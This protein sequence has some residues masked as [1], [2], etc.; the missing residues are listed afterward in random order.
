MTEW[1][2]LLITL[3][4]IDLLIISNGYEKIYTDPSGYLEYAMSKVIRLKSKFW[5]FFV[6]SIYEGMLIFIK[7][8]SKPIW[9]WIQFSLA[10]NHI[11][12]RLNWSENISWRWHVGEL[13]KPC[14][15]SRFHHY[16]QWHWHFLVSFLTC[17][18]I[19]H[20]SRGGKVWGFCFQLNF[21]DTESASRVSF[22][23]Q[24][25]DATCIM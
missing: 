13:M 3:N 4:N 17:K 21:T 6:S 18:E 8:V 16:I 22:F 19:I 1:S 14:L 25:K 15:F 5:N 11:S 9:D 24:R 23:F 20:C 12:N 10:G 7:I 2:T